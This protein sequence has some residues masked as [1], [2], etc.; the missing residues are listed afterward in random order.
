[1]V[2]DFLPWRHLVF[3]RTTSLT[4]E[5]IIFTR[6][7]WISICKCCFSFRASLVRV[8]EGSKPVIPPPYSH[9]TSLKFNISSLP[10]N[11]AGAKHRCFLIT[12]SFVVP[13]RLCIQHF[14]SLQ[15]NRFSE[16]ILVRN[17]FLHIN[18]RS[19]NANRWLPFLLRRIK[20]TPDSSITVSGITL[21]SLTICRYFL[22]RK[23]CF[24][25]FLYCKL[26]KYS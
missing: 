9:A 4:Q 17:S 13:D 8:P 22:Y 6:F 19:L 2:N 10:G 7:L 26:Q 20:S 18:L 14:I 23:K 12:P 25:I 24:T 1:M 16:T 15:V 5:F 21:F 11:L 3:W